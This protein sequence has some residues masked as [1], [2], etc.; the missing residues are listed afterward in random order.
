MTRLKVRPGVSGEVGEVGDAELE[1]DEGWW[2][3]SCV[4]L[5]VVGLI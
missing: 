4:P 2:E 5:S 1:L 3:A